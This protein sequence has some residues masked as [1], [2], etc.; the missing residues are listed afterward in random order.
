MLESIPEEKNLCSFFFYAGICKDSA[1][2]GYICSY[3]ADL[4]EGGDSAECSVSDVL[5]VEHISESFGE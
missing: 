1:K 5:W 4:F 3:A 2:Q